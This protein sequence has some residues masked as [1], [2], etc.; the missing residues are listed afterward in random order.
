MK[1][2]I[3]S[4]KLFEEED[5]Y[6]EYQEKLAKVGKV[7]YFCDIESG[8]PIIEL[9][10]N[11]LEDLVELSN[12]VNTGLKISRPYNEGQPFQLWIVDGYME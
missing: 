3:Y 12:Q 11:C 2:Q 9:E 7:S 1:F 10:L 4:A 8:N 5:T 6:K